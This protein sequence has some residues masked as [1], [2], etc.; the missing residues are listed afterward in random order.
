MGHQLLNSQGSHSFKD[1]IGQQGENSLHFFMGQ[2][3][4][5]IERVGFWGSTFRLVPFGG[6]NGTKIA[7]LCP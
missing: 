6:L 7:W 3:F 2:S 5:I 1:M 4:R